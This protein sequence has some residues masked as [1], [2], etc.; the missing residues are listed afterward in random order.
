MNKQIDREALEAALLEAIDNNTDDKDSADEYGVRCFFGLTREGATSE[1]AYRSMMDDLVAVVERFALKPVSIELMFRNYLGE[2]FKEL[3][4]EK[5]SAEGGL[6]VY[7]YRPAGRLSG[8]KYTCKASL[9][10]VDIGAKHLDTAITEC[11][12]RHSFEKDNGPAVQWGDL[13]TE[14]QIAGDGRVI[15]DRNTKEIATGDFSNQSGDVEP[16]DTPL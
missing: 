8:I 11:R 6:E 14:K 15:T 13:S 2:K 9:D 10:D 4:S 1:E 3:V 7:I 16:T 12:R 5:D